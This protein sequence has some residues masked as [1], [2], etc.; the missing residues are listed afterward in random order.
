MA[1]K[2]VWVD[3]NIVDVHGHLGSF[4]GY[5]LSTETLMENIDRFG[6]KLVLVSNIDGAHLP[7]KTLDL[8]EVTANRITL[9]TVKKYPD[10]LRGLVWTRP[11]DPAGSPQ[12]VEPFLR[13]HGFVGVKLHPEMN[14]FPADSSCVDGYLELCEKYNVPAVFHCGATGS[15]SGPERIYAAARRHPSVP[16][17]LYHMGFLGPHQDAIAAVKGALH[18]KDA[19]LYLETSQAEPDA[20]LQA[21]AAVGADRILFG[22]DAT[23]Y[24]GKHYEKYAAMVEA[25]QRNLKQ[26]DFAKIIRLNAMKLFRLQ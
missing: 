1:Q 19:N 16:V 17:I 5:D 8:D 14:Q 13:D 18:D 7:G 25:L 26:D 15:T 4:R 12:N 11:T 23:Y 22:T 9:E 6:I 3:L 21:F 10:R 2:P 24:G 20:V